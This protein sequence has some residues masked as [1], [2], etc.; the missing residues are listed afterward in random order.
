MRW[1]HTLCIQ[2]DGVEDLH[3]ATRGAPR[4]RQVANVTDGA[5]L[6]EP[7]CVNWRIADRMNDLHVA[8]VVDIKTVFQAHDQTRAIQLHR[9]NRV[10]IRIIA[11]FCSLLKVTHFQLSRRIER[12][13]GHQRTAEKSL[14][15][16]N[17]LAFAAV[18]L[19]QTRVHR[20]QRK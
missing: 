10:G 8:N 19:L 4:V 17:V 2:V 1:Y 9:E 15:Q 18:N 3:L 12:H 6:A 13:N 11:D 7:I 16:A 5:Q 14:H 20:I